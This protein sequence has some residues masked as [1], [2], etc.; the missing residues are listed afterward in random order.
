MESGLR[1]AL[2]LSALYAGIF[3]VL[4]NLQYAAFHIGGDNANYTQILWNT[5]HGRWLQKTSLYALTDQLRGGHI[6]PILLLLAPFYWLVPDPR[7]L[8]V[9]QTLVLAL[10][11]LLVYHVARMQGRSQPVAVG[12]VV[13]YLVYPIVHY[14]NIADFH[15]DP[16]AVP[17]ILGA[18]WAFDTRRWGWLALCV[19][20]TLLVKEELVVIVLGLGLYWALCRGE[21]RVGM[22]TV[23]AAILYSVAVLLPW[24]LATKSQVLHDYQGYFGNV[25][26]AWQ[27]GGAEPNTFAARSHR[28]FALLTQGFR[29]QNEIWALLPAGCLFL[30]DTSALVLLLPL[31]GLYV[32]DLMTNYFFYHHYIVCVP[33]LL[34]GTARALGRPVFAR[35][36]GRI[37][38]ILVVW[39]CAL[40]YS[41]SMAPLNLMHWLH[42]PALIASSAHSRAQEAIVRDIPADVPVDAD[43]ALAA[44]LANRIY[45]FQLQDV[46]QASL[47][48]YILLDLHADYRNPPPWMV[49]M[50]RATLAYMRA[51]GGFRV[52]RADSAHGLYIY[53]N[54]R[55]FPTT[56]GCARS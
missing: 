40:D 18:L 30:L 54:C 1:W 31:A 19:A 4:G 5:I 27:G 56:T 45:L 22:L 43:Y 14:A 8:L 49:A 13:F 21:R 50:D 47:A 12:L 6:D 23:A 51:T 2:L 15:C 34:Y 20:L 26:H 53:L 9:G 38:V 41:Y 24:F 55:R 10:G 17:T 3:I 37:V 48:P 35:R 42:Q 44:H 33:I 25:L 28:L 32:S 46:R 16:L 36:N 29:F 52:W 11:G 39:A 7:T